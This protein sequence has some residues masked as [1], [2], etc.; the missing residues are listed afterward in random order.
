VEEPE[1]LYRRFADIFNRRE[2]DALDSVMSANFV[3]HH[4][5]LVDVTQLD[6]YKRNLASV[7]NATEMIA[8]IDD[9]VA[10][11]DKAFTR[12]TLTGRHVKEFLG[13]PPTGNRL[14]WVT[15]ELWRAEHGLMVERWAVDDLLT[16]LHQMGVAMPLWSDS[17]S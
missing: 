3:D 2:Y 1:A 13:V 11:G 12:I 10:T 16:L 8:R 5:G 15:H 6:I 7:I 17:K 4:P 9:I 14:E